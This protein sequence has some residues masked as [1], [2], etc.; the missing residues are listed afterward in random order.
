MGYFLWLNDRITTNNVANATANIN[1]SNTDNG[2]MGPY[3]AG[4]ADV[5]SGCGAL[6]PPSY[7]SNGSE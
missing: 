5:A 1:A 2:T 4:H 6:N 7:Y 3:D